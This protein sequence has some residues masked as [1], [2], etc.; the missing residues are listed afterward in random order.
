MSRSKISIN[1]RE[2]LGGYCPH[3]RAHLLENIEENSA[4]LKIKR[5]E[6]KKK[7]EKY[8]NKNTHAENAQQ[9]G[10]F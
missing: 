6:K 9:D 4:D 2:E 7:K 10:I 8:K 1:S 3:R 5:A